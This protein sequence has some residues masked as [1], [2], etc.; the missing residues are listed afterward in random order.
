MAQTD[1]FTSQF[2]TCPEGLRLRRSELTVYQLVQWLP[3]GHREACPQVPLTEGRAWQ[4]E[5]AQP[6][7]T[8]EEEGVSPRGHGVGQPLLR[9]LMIEEL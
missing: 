7:G 3:G 5:V 6:E 2:P 1:A 9:E 8:E 4:A